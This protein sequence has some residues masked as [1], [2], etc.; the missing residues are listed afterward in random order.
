MA[1]LYTT[2]SGLRLPPIEYFLTLQQHNG[3]LKPCLSTHD[4][5]INSFYFFIFFSFTHSQNLDLKLFAI[6]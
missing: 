4:F 3:L 5:S 6:S 1:Y 2:L